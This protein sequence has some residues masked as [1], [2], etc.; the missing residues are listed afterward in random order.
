MTNKDGAIAEETAAAVETVETQEQAAAEAVAEVTENAEVTEAAEVAAV[1]ESVD[2]AE[3]V[4]ETAEAAVEAPKD[5][6]KPVEAEAKQEPKKRDLPVKHKS[7][8]EKMVDASIVQYSKGK[9]IKDAIVISS[10]ARGINI[11]IGGKNDGFIPAE[12]A[13]LEGE[14]KPEDFN[15][16]DKLDAIITGKDGSTVLLSKKEVDAIKAV[17]KI[18]DTIRN[19]EHFTVKVKT[20]EKGLLSRLGSYRVFVPQSHVADVF[21]KD[22]SGFDGKRLTMKALK[23]DDDKREV[24]ASVKEAVRIERE[25]RAVEFFDQIQVDMVVKGKIMRLAKFGAFVDVNGFDCLAHIGELSWNKINNVSEVLKEGEEHEFLVLRVDKDK[26]KVSLGYKQLQPHPFDNIIEQFPIGST[27][28][29]KVVRLC[30]FG[31]FVEISN[32]VDGLVHISEASHNYVKDISEVLKVNDTVTAILTKIDPDTRKISLSIKAATEAPEIVERKPFNKFDR[33]SEEGENKEQSFRK[34]KRPRPPKSSEESA[35]NQWSET[36][37]NNPF[38]ELA[39]L[40][41]NE[42]E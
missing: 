35:N 11:S 39:V 41:K 20:I 36:A 42:D 3:L 9:R 12:E 33:K 38:S 19:G 25:K 21:L 29:G 22:I 34:E 14:Y 23:I 4:T 16:G 32:G 6:S 8:F 7:E 30:Q 27:V 40:L 2:A 1:I 5:E 13:V 28:T 10:D 18:I 24:V 17:D 26:R 37:A 15:P 31:A